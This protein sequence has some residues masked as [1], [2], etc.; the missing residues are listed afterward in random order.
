MMLNSVGIDELTI[1]EK[2]IK[3]IFELLTGA[4]NLPQAQRVSYINDHNRQQFKERH[5]VTVNVFNQSFFI[6]R[7]DNELLVSDFAEGALAFILVA[8]GANAS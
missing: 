2:K 4:G 8:P 5:G 1:D 6:S 3:F 7:K